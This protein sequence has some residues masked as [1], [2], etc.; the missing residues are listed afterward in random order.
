MVSSEKFLIWIGVIGN[1]GTMKR[2]SDNKEDLSDA[3]KQTDK[4]FYQIFATVS[5]TLRYAVGLSDKWI[6]LFNRKCEVKFVEIFY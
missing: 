5:G 6:I 4:Y 2:S 1:K 3:N